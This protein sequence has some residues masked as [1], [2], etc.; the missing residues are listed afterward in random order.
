MKIE[1]VFANL[2]IVFICK[3]LS[4]KT[5]R[6]SLNTA[7]ISYILLCLIIL[8]QHY[9]HELYFSILY[10]CLKYLYTFDNLSINLNEVLQL[11]KVF[12]DESKL[13]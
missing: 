1:L 8:Y 5:G 2:S 11:E 3:L 9:T 7:Y 13:I 4:L 10:V 6:M 12:F